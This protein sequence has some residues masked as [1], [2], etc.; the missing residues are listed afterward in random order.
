MKHEDV[1]VPKSSTCLGRFARTKLENRT[2]MKHFFRFPALLS[3]FFPIF[4]L[5]LDIRT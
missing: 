3:T 5:A 1:Q 2:L 4:A